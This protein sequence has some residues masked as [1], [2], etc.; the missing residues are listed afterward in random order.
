MKKLREITITDTIYVYCEDNEVSACISIARYS[1]LN[2]DIEYQEIITD[3]EQIIDEW[4]NSI[5]WS[6]DAT[7]NRTCAEI[8]R[9][10]LSN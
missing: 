3:P 6:V 2:L 10:D 9:E 8:L 5:P 4:K 1:D 7:D